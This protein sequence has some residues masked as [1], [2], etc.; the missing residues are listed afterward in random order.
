MLRVASGRAEGSDRVHFQVLVDVNGHGHREVVK[1]WAL[2]GPGDNAE[3]V[4]TIML[5]DED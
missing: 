1:L 3:P 5:K 2:C 4:V